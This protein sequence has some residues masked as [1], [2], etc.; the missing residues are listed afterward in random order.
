MQAF[1]RCDFRTL[2]LLGYSGY[3]YRGEAVFASITDHPG[4]ALME[5]ASLTAAQT[6]ADPVWQ[7]AFRNDL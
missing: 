2:E 7:P 6:G 1:A 4:I 3:R 5:R